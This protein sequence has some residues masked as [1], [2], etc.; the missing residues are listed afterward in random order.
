MESKPFIWGLY[1]DVVSAGVIN[2][3]GGILC[4]QEFSLHSLLTERFLVICQIMH[5]LRLHLLF[6]YYHL[7]FKKFQH[8]SSINIEP[9]IQQRQQPKDFWQVI[10]S[11]IAKLGI[12]VFINE[13]FHFYL[14]KTYQWLKDGG[15]SVAHHPFSYLIFRINQFQYFIFEVR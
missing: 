2:P 12:L 9:Q 6:S 10:F 11:F 15:L 7:T 3:L 5:L 13:K 14:S 8:P 1:L 4:G